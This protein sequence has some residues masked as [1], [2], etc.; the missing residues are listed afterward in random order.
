MW[1]ASLG[2]PTLLRE[3][4]MSSV[5]LGH[6]EQKEKHMPRSIPEAERIACVAFMRTPDRWP[7]WP[8]LPVKNVLRDW[9]DPHHMG[10]MLDLG[11]PMR[12]NIPASVVISNMYAFDASKLDQYEQEKYEDYDAMVKAGWVVD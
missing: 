4:Y 6:G 11:G 8:I 3:P 9:S 5:R 2:L 10:I 12:K 1:L 7:R